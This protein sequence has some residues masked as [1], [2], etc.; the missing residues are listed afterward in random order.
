MREFTSFGAFAL[1]LERLSLEGAEVT[2]HLTTH[3]A[4]T[5]RDIAKAKIGYYQD[6]EGGFPAWAPLAAS[7]EAEKRRLGA[8][9]GAPLL[10]HGD[11]YASIEFQAEMNILEGNAVVGS[12]SDIAVYQ[13]LGTPTIP[14]RPFLGPAG[15]ESRETIAL[16]ASETII[17]WVSGRPWRPAIQSGS[18]LP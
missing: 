5:V 17:S 14:P 10:R 9:A 8:P 6:A 1:H 15:F 16:E 11:L 7:T 4:E 12:D 18:K 2:E 13:E 3:A